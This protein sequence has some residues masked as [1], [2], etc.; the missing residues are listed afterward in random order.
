[1]V[2]AEQ[3]MYAAKRFYDIGQGNGAFSTEENFTHL[4][5]ELLRHLNAK[6]TVN[7]F[8]EKARELK[9]SVYRAWPFPFIRV[10]I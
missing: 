3:E 8:M 6:I 1:V 10:Y 5:D 4:R 7:A 2:G 9:V